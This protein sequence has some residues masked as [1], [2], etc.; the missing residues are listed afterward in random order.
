MSRTD[1]A[2][3][4]RCMV[5][6]SVAPPAASTARWCIG[7]KGQFLCRSMG[8]ISAPVRAGV[9]V[10]R[11]C[12]RLLKKPVQPARAFHLLV[13]VCLPGEGHDNRDKD[14]HRP[15]DNESPQQRGPNLPPEHLPVELELLAEPRLTQVPVRHD[16]APPDPSRSATSMLDRRP[17]RA[18]S[19]WSR[20]PHRVRLDPA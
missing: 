18:L 4:T 13:H 9:R 16:P 20:I 8:P 5:S 14:Q 17:A 3:K 10:K 15:D 1:T 7:T 2:T 19:G 12:V 11:T 6:V